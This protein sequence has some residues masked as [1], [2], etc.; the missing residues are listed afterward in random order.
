MLLAIFYV[1]ILIYNKNGKNK[2]R[3]LHG[4]K[5]TNIRLYECKDYIGISLL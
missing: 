2:W 3:N 1:E 4:Q 5:G